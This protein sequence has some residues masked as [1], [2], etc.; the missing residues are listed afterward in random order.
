M[1]SDFPQVTLSTQGPEHKAHNWDQS[2]ELYISF[3][4]RTVLIPGS[5]VFPAT[6]EHLQVEP[7]PRAMTTQVHSR[8]RPESQHFLLLHLW[9]LISGSWRSPSPAFELICGFHISLFL[10]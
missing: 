7:P 9:L 5:S 8:H 2:V 3:N 1:L 10:E 4:G 6:P